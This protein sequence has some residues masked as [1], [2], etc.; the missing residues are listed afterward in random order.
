M[1]ST[2]CPICHSDHSHLSHVGFDDRHG[3]PD[4]FEIHVCNTCSHHMTTPRLQEADLGA[5]YSQYYQRKNIDP[6]Q[7]L[8]EARDIETTKNY[9]KRWWNGTDNQGQYF[10]KPGENILDIG[11]GSGLSLLEAN[12]LGANAFGIDVDPNTQLIADALGLNVHIGTLR[13]NPFPEIQFD[14]IVLNQV[15]EHIPEPQHTLMLLKKRLKSGGRLII[16]VPNRQSIWQYLFKKRWIHWHIPY[17]IHH[18]DAV[19]LQ[20]F[21]ENC[22][23]QV[24]K[25]RTI[26]PNIW[27]IL[28]IR[29]LLYKPIQGQANALWGTSPHTSPHQEK[30]RVLTLRSLLISF[31]RTVF[32]Y[33]LSILNRLLDICKKGDSLLIELKMKE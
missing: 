3:Y 6:Q 33:G 8:K 25:K 28:Q 26:T 14:L 1:T 21:V 24:T 22:G 13:D 5:L 2:N 11:C 32:F 9:L 31:A 17:H 27:T 18:F 16:C 30:K 4:L 29:S 12:A 23:Y 19:G 7:L 20:T 15:L 10:V